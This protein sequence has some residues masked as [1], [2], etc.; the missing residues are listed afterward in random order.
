MIHKLLMAGGSLQTLK[1]CIMCLVSCEL[2]YTPCIAWGVLA[3]VAL[4]AVEPVRC[5]CAGNGEI[6]GGD[7]R[8]GTWG[9]D[10]GRGRAAGAAGRRPGRAE[11]WALV[12]E[13]GVSGQGGWGLEFR[14][15]WVTELS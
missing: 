10:T 1:R 8:T 5:P 14:W 7:V 13:A 15:S 2:S 9:Q 12:W 6:P 4:K 3:V 11:V